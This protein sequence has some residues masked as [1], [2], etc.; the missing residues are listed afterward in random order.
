MSKAFQKAVA[1]ARYFKNKGEI[2]MWRSVWHDGKPYDYHLNTDLDLDCPDRSHVCEVYVYACIKKQD[3]FYDTDTS[4]T[5]HIHRFRDLPKGYDSCCKC[6]SKE[7][8][9]ED[10]EQSFAPVLLCDD[11]YTKLKVMVANYVNC[12]LQSLEM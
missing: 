1:S 6:G 5:L 9:M 3:G 8:P 12:N 7:Q 4:K 2:D 10:M 11:C